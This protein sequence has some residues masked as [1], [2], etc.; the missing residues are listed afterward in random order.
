MKMMIGLISLPLCLLGIATLSL[1]A[2]AESQEVCV[3]TSVGDVACGK[4]IA[5][6]SSGPKSPAV[7]PLPS[8]SDSKV[9]SYVLR[10]HINGLQ[11]T[12]LKITGNRQHVC[13]VLLPRG[14]GIGGS[15]FYPS[16]ESLWKGLRCK[17]LYCDL[18]DVK[19][20]ISLRS[21]WSKPDP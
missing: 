19:C 8:V 11:T 10:D 17:E 7:N 2:Q 1:P 4:P 6:P 16:E 14:P 20:R 18:S 13:N 9:Q 3:L 21:Q 12:G 5:K 15:F